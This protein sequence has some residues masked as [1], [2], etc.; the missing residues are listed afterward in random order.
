VTNAG[1]QTRVDALVDA[2]KLGLQYALPKLALTRFAGWVAGG[3]WGA[4][5]T[6]LIRWFI[7]KYQVNMAEAAQADPAA[8][9]TFNA[10]F[11]RALQAGARPLAQA[12]WLCPV[13]GAVSQLGRITG[14]A[15]DQIFQAKGHQ[16][17][18]CA[19]LGGDVA[20]AQAFAH[21]SFCTLY[22][23]PR[24]YHRIHMPC[25]GRLLRML[26]VPRAVCPQRARGV[27]F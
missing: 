23:S 26:H 5:T 2:I 13:D 19:L 14:V 3:R 20:L 17:S 4:G 25:D 11:T 22:L 10:F 16:Y 27:H 7:A 1:S 24:D 6:A 8:Y 18:T 21:G 9:E 15:G 12:D